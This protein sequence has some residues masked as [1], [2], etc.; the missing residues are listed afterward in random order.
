MHNHLRLLRAATAL[1]YLGPLLAGLLGQGWTMVPAFTIVFLIWSVIIRPHLWPTGPGDLARSDAWVAL[2]TL[3]VT[4]LL[5]VVVSFAIGRG[6]GGVLGAHPPLPYYLPLSLSILA[7]PLSRLIWNPR[8][9][10]AHVGFDPLAEKIVSEPPEPDPVKRILGP[11]MALPDDVADADLQDHLSAI[12]SH[13]DPA[14]IRQ[15]LVNAAAAEP[16]SRAGIKA[17]ILHATAPGVNTVV[18]GS[19]Y[20]AQ[21]FAA[22]GYDAEL[23][24]LFATRCLRAVKLDATFATDCPSVDRVASAA[25]KVADPTAALLERLAGVLAQ[26][27]S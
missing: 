7:V 5:I 20:P 21:A 14:A 2:I 19:G 1:L 4:Q 6:I 3:I 24:S 18:A 17:L 23:L 9:A 25:Q 27:Q 15:G 13:L 26:T 8:L 11:L 12:A 22:A 10:E 16:A